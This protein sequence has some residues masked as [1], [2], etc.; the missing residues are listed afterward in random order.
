[1]DKT[2]PETIVLKVSKLPELEVTD[3]MTRVSYL[4][5]YSFLLL[6]SLPF[7]Y[8][9]NA[10]VLAHAVHCDSNNGRFLLGLPGIMRSP[11]IG[12]DWYLKLARDL[13][14]PHTTS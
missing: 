14:F 2:P 8:H 1:M 10:L 5:S 9:L 3:N 11:N 7:W 6:L 13:S 12:T 4:Y